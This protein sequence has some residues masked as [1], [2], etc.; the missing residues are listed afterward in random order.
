M[1]SFGERLK[2]EREKKQITLDQVSVSTKISVRMLRAIEEEKFDQLPG[3]IFNKGFVR[4][5][6]RHLGMDEE[7]AVADYLAASTPVSSSQPEDVELRA[8]AEQKDKER[9]RQARIR[10]DFPWEWVAAVLILIAVGF[11]VWGVRSGREA[12]SGKTPNPESS[13]KPEN[14]TDS[15]ATLPQTDLKSAPPPHYA[16]TVATENSGPTPVTAPSDGFTVHVVAQDDSWLSIIADEK[17]VFTGTLLASGQQSV[18]AKN[19]IIIRAGN[20]GGLDIDFNG[21]RLSP[22]GDDGEVKTLTFHSDGLAPP[23]PVPATIPEQ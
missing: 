13:A 17:P 10:K 12:Q 2:R 16:P 18:R 9:L 15:Q 20:V 21:K 11:S 1:A 8:M 7:Q 23:P 22:Q 5:Y 19:S 4:A 14:V 3:G 6:A